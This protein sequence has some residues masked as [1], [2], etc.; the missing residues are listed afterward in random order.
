M[1]DVRNDKPI[2]P[3]AQM[4]QAAIR[5]RGIAAA[6]VN[7][8]KV[9]V[10][11]NADSQVGHVYPYYDENGAHVANKVRRKGEKAFYWEGDTARGTLFG[12]QLFPDRKSTRLN[13]VT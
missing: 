13:S 9:T 1:N 6:T 11:T 2:T 7:K 10:N 5:D 3:V 8:Y 12:Q 4:D